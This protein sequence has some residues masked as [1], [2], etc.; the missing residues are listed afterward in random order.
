MGFA[1]EDVT[2]QGQRKFYR[3]SKIASRGFCPDCGTQMSFES[4]RWPG[5]IHLYGASRDDPENF[6]PELHCHYAERL[7]WLHMADDLPKYATTAGD[8]A[9]K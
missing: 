4:T 3:S 7:A 1:P 5:E 8:A 6:E 2:W 9:D